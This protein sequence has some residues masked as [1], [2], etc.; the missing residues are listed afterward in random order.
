MPVLKKLEFKVGDALVLFQDGHGWMESVSSLPTPDAM[1]LR[2]TS[3][4]MMSV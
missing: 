4:P 2:I 1:A 3:C